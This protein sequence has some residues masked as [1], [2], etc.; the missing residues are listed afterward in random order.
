MTTLGNTHEQ[1]SPR[2]TLPRGIRLA[3]AGAILVCG[4]FQ[5]RNGILELVPALGFGANS[6]VTAMSQKAADATRQLLGMFKDVPRNGNPPRQTDATVG[7]LLA[8]VFD[9]DILKTKTSLGKADLEALGN[10]VMS[11]GQVGSLYLFAGTGLSDPEK[12]SNGPK[13]IQQVNNNVA[14]YA[15]E[16]GRYFDA[17][18]IINGTVAE[19]VAENFSGK[20]NEAAKAK[21]RSGV[22]TAI[23]GVID[24]FNIESISDE[25]RR[26]R[27]LALDY[28][29][30]KAA[31]LLSADQCMELRNFS[32]STAASMRDPAVKS[33]LE[34][35]VT[36]LKC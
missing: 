34:N 19:V 17:A 7:P 30:P 14:V 9:A 26:G 32:H 16:V 28:A 23:Y 13:L 31:K 3:V 24:S 1:S 6:E 10:W 18:L 15:P 5:A 11:A 35:V 12:V 36:A 33:G 8:T 21:V 22:A 2:K 27:L 20:T 29:A 4:I 25:W